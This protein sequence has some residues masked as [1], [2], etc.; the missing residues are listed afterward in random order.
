MQR[1]VIVTGGSTGIGRQLVKRFCEGGDRV[2]FSY[3]GAAEPAET[4]VA[5][6]SGSALAL[7][8]DVGEGTAVERFFDAACEWAGA[9]PD[10]LVNNAG[11]QTWAGLLD[12]SEADWNRVI[13]TNLTGAFLNTKAAAARMA[14]AMRPGA[15]VNIGSGCNKIAFPKLV[16]YTASKGGVEQ[17]T[18]VAAVELGPKGIRVNCVAPGAIATERTFEEAPDYGETWGKVTPLGRVGTPDD[19]AEAV[20]FLA[21]DAARFITGQT[22]WVDGGLFSRPVWPYDE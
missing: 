11:V 14:A 6:L 19:V 9:A 12:L 1:F 20:L 16:D 22:L 18:K 4:L 17:F 10:V 13:R 8:A 7:T 3:L 15:I 5:E 2:A 21:S